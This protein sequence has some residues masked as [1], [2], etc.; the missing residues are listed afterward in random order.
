MTRTVTPQRRIDDV[1][2]FGLTRI[3]AP[4]GSAAWAMH[5]LVT[6]TQPDAVTVGLLVLVAF[7]L[8]AG[9]HYSVML[10]DDRLNRAAA[11]STQGTEAEK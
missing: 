1:A 7:A 8:F 2:T 5:Q 11:G 4:F 9:F 10:A 6:R 3:V